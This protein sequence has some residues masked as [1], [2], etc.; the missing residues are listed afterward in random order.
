MSQTSTIWN[1]LMSLHRTNFIPKVLNRSKSIYNRNSV[2]FNATISA[3]AVHM[4]LLENME[5]KLKNGSQCLD[6]GSGTGFLTACMGKIAGPRGKVVGIEHVPE[7]TKIAISNMKRE[8]LTDVVDMLNYDGRVGCRDKVSLFDV[9]NIGGCVP[10]VKDEIFKQ[11]APN[12]ILIATLGRGYSDQITTKF[13]K[14]MFGKIYATQISNQFAFAP[15]TDLEYQLSNEYVNNPF[16]N[17]HM[18]LK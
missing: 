18:E 17:Y 10:Y 14:D 2:G 15:L 11:L 6:I 5:E 7:L 4:F 8:C 1:Q 16:N 3:S 13:T 9:I 12:G